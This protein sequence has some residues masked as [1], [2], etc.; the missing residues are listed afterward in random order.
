M[1]ESIEDDRRACSVHLAAD[2]LAVEILDQTRMPNREVWVR[3][4]ELFP[5][6]RR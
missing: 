2:G 1:N 5:R 6:I 4:R 3:L